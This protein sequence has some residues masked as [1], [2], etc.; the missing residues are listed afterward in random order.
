MRLRILTVFV[1]IAMLSVGF[2]IVLNDAMAA[3]QAAAKLQCNGPATVSATATWFWDL[4]GP[5]STITCT[6]GGSA[7]A[8]PGRPAQAVAFDL[9]ITIEDTAGNTKTCHLIGFPTPGFDFAI[10]AARCSIED[11]P[12]SALFRL[13]APS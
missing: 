11:P 9:F 4:T 10:D 6:G 2:I 1:V 5:I 3:R 13:F 8:D 7:T 12:G